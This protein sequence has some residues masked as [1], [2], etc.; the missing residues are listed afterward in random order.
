MPFPVTHE[1]ERKGPFSRRSPP[2]EDNDSEPE[3]I[4][5]NQ[6]PTLGTFSH[7]CFA[8][9]PSYLSSP[10]RFGS[11]SDQDGSYQFPPPA[12]SRKPATSRPA[13]VSS[14][15][16]DFIQDFTLKLSLREPSLRKPRQKL[17]PYGRPPIPW[18]AA[19]CTLLPPA[20]HP[21]PSSPHPLLH[22]HPFLPSLRLHLASTP[23]VHQ[24][25]AQ[26]PR[27]TISLNKSIRRF[28]DPNRTPKNTSVSPSLQFCSI[29]AILCFFAIDF[30]RFR[31]IFFVYTFHS[32]Q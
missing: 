29:Q 3:T 2:Q 4:A 19:T 8:R 20:P 26:P 14:N 25:P 31:H 18:F 32:I 28:G 10:L 17:D 13:C 21:A 16:E 1:A 5:V 11:F 12:W 23:S 6:S 7:R 27:C 24:A 9:F 30:L 15:L 22:R